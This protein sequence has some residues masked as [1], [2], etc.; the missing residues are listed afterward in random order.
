MIKMRSMVGR[1]VPRAPRR[2]TVL[3]SDSLVGARRAR[4]DAPYHPL[5]HSSLAGFLNLELI[6]AI[7]IL[8][9]VMLPLG[10]AW[11]HEEAVKAER[12]RKM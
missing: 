12:A 10:G 1:V 5:V 4:S 9:V 6:I 11:Y 3:E 2:T 8:A 7:A